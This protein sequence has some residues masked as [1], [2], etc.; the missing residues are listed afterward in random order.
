ML[1]QILLHVLLALGNQASS[2]YMQESSD[3]NHIVYKMYTEKQTC[4]K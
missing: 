2:A 4:I 1:A 3:P